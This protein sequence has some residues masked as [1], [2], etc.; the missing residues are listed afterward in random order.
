MTRLHGFVSMEVFGQVR[1]ML[2]HSQSY[3]A[4]MLDAELRHCGIE[5]PR[6]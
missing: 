4:E 5:P 1:I 6:S 2:P 3:F